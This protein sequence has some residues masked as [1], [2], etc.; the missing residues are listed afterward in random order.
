MRSVITLAL[1]AT[2]GL[3]SRLEAQSPAFARFVDR[4]LDDFARRH[5]SIAA[6]NG[7]HDH[8]DRLDDFSAAGIAAEV[9]ALERDAVELR[10]FDPK[11]LTPDERVD[12]RILLGIIDGWLLE[13]K[14]L[15]N[16]RRNPMLYAS[17]LADGVHNL[18]TMTSDPA[19]VRMRRIIAKLR[20]LPAFLND[21][22]TNVVNPPRLFAERGAG[23]MRGAQEM[24]GRDLDAA[25]AA[26]PNA[27]LRDSLRKAA[28]VAIPQIAAYVAYLERDVIP[29][30]TGDFTI[31]AANL[32]RRYLAE[33]LIDT[34]LET[35]VAIGEGELARS[36]SEFRAAA[37]KLDAT[38]DPV[39]VWEQVR[40]DH[41][42]MG[43]VVA[44]TQRIVD[45]LSA[46]V[47]ARGIATLPPNERV[48]VAP[49]LPFDLGFASMHASPPLEKTPVKSIYYITD[50]QPGLSPAEQEAWLERYNYASLTNTS[51]HEA[52]PGHWLH[53]TYMRR[54]PGKVRRIWI[55]LNPFPQ[56]SS[57][58]D[59]WAH[60]AEQM[61]LDEGYG[62]GDPKLRLAQLSDALTR[63]CRLL[64]GIKMQ[65]KQWTL[66]DAQRC[67]EQDAYVA[68]PAA[69]REAERGAYDP[70]YGGYFLGKRAILKLRADYQKRMGPK[71]SLREFHE[72][73]M[74]NGIAPIWAQRQLLLP[75]DTGAVI[76]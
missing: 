67:F 64:S 57:G 7:I 11:T 18:M 2:V 61:V 51:A 27:A 30:A 65:T 32:S 25:F 68:A 59:G 63:I 48:I 21:A 45:S 39:K 3:V 9:K 69:K 14:T 60:Y 10:A 31:G 19:P 44:A 16:W 4:Y 55:G 29:K 50:A 8:D 41:P 23:F 17:A 28:D 37:A 5:P 74:T 75:G 35:M 43:G 70:T 1:I 71:F 49:A 34:P 6:G 22:K 72:R 20:Q 47:A 26:E 66:A 40:K 33:E 46:F 56:P 42:K 73:F 53:S 24:L 58:Q 12:Q 13:Q 62:N 15:Q 36:K 76:Q 52:M 54:T 38:R